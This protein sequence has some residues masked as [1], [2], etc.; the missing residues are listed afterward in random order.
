MKHALFLIV[1]FIVLHLIFLIVAGTVYYCYLQSTQIVAGEAVRLLPFSS[2]FPALPFILA[3]ASIAA[4]FS[5]QGGCVRTA[6]G[7]PAQIA[8]ALLV[9]AVWC[10]IIPACAKLRERFFSAGTNVSPVERISPGF[11]RQYG[12]GIFFAVRGGETAS[13]VF[14]QSDGSQLPVLIEDLPAESLRVH[15]YSDALV[16][17]TV[18]TPAFLSLLA[19]E[20]VF[21]A[22]IGQNAAGGGYFSWLC[23]ASMCLPF[24]A[25]SALA[26]AGS[27]KLKNATVMIFVFVAIVA[28]NH[29]Y[30]TLDVSGMAESGLPAGQNLDIAH[31]AFNALMAVIIS[32]LGVA[33]TLLASRRAKSSG[34]Y[35]G[36]G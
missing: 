17:N 25:I 8:S 28:A 19:D 24:A 34:A 15:P 31:V 4:G 9:I 35:L 16:A 33:A 27:W 22:R 32:L 7:L 30:Y 14:L 20:A 18:R 6:A 10:A 13:G 36:D 5:A 3:C 11:F 21:F 26:R 1:K 29:L 2:A 12:N 23:F